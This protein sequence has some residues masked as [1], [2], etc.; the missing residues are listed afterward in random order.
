MSCKFLCFRKSYSLNINHDAFRC[1]LVRHSLF[2]FS[3]RLPS[4]ENSEIEVDERGCASEMRDSQKMA[5]NE[6]LGKQ[7]NCTDSFTTENVERH[8]IYSIYTIFIPMNDLFKTVETI[9]IYIH[10]NLHACHCT[11][12]QDNQE[13]MSYGGK[14]KYVKLCHISFYLA[15]Y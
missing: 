10:Y 4:R 15:H 8:S 13:S 3:F 12:F 6:I 9:Y 1:L 14:E 11:I 2:F 5:R 7:E